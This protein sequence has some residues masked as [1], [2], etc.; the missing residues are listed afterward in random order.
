MFS[1]VADIKAKV[2][3]IKVYSKIANKMCAA[4]PILT[5]AFPLDNEPPCSSVRPA[6]DAFGLAKIR[7][8]TRDYF[9]FGSLIMHDFSGRPCRP[10]AL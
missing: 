10:F 3:R 1:P 9:F 6:P 4:R 8:C 5:V 2:V 7:L